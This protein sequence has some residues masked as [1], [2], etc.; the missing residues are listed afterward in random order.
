MPT[1]IPIFE[2][3]VEGLTCSTKDAVLNSKL[4][5]EQDALMVTLFFTFAL[6]AGIG[7]YLARFI[8]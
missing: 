4:I 5:M 7:Y 6:G 3:K 2:Q 8:F 1:F